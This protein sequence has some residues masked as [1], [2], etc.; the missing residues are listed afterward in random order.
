[1]L[2]LVLTLCLGLLATPARASGPNKGS[3]ERADALASTG[4]APFTDIGWG[5]AYLAAL[6]RNLTV[7]VQV[8][9]K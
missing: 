4:D 5:R 9:A 8:F 1:M 2:C 3:T 6:G 7:T